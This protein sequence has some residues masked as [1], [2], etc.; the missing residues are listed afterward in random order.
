MH[1]YTKLNLFKVI[2]VCRFEIN[3]LYFD[4][5]LIWTL[6]TREFKESEGR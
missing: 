1:I 3:E 2:N 5:N 4:R 6:I